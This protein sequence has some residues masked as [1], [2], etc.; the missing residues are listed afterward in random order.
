MAK[1]VLTRVRTLVRTRTRTRVCALNVTIT[2]RWGCDTGPL[3][4]PVTLRYTNPSGLCIPHPLGVVPP[5]RGGKG[6]GKPKADRAI[7]KRKT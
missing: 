3:W 4:G 5:Q 7:T 1:I 6:A 2:P